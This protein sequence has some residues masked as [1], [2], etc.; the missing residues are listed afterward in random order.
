MEERRF[1][2]LI[3][4][5]ITISPLSGE[6]PTEIQKKARTAKQE[7]KPSIRAQLAQDK[8]AVK[9]APKKAIEQAKK[10]DLERS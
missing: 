8:E 9:A 5:R 10:T 7:E 4:C 1:W 3:N 6:R 2:V